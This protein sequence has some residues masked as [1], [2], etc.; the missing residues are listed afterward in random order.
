MAKNSRWRAVLVVLILILPSLIY[1][2]LTTGKHNTD[3][4]P[5]YGVKPDGSLH[6]V[7]SFSFQ[8]QFG[9]Q[10]DDQL[11]ESHITVWSFYCPDCND[12]LSR[13]ATLIKDVSDR[14]FDKKDIRFLSLNISD[15]IDQQP[16][17]EYI[18]PFGAL[19]DRW[20]YL[21]NSTEEAIEFAR[22]SLLIGGADYPLGL[23]EEQQ[24]A[25]IVVVDKKGRIRGYA[26]GIQYL[27]EKELIDI[28]KYVRLE[29]YRAN[30]KSRSEQ[31]ERKR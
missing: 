19:N 1:V 16:I 11:M 25:T 9:N 13:V 30:S 3:E 21:N 6:E 15:T 4:M 2:A 18:R 14:F 27:S 12:S 23:K 22:E 5:I 28:I 10:I 26:D 31:F 20:H 29:E 7:K 8:D 17:A 24:W